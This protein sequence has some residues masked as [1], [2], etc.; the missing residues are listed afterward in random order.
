MDKTWYDA[1]CH[2]ITYK[3]IRLHCIWKLRKPVFSFQS[4]IGDLFY[5]HPVFWKNLCNFVRG[6]NSFS[7]IML[8]N[9]HSIIF[10]FDKLIHP[11]EETRNNRNRKTLSAIVVQQFNRNL[12]KFG[13]RLSL[14]NRNCDINWL[15]FRGDWAICTNKL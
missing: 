5:G 12:L 10:V 14:C 4:I 15:Q 8:H 11:T 6:E 7:G 9:F 2:I 1:Q 13:H 3:R